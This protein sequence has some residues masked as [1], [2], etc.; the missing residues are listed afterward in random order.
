RQRHEELAPEQPEPEV[1]RQLAQAQL[2]QPRPQPAEDQQRNEDDDQ[3]ADH[4]VCVR[5]PAAKPSGAALKAGSQPLAKPITLNSSPISCSL[6]SFCTSAMTGS[7][8]P[9]SS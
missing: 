8:A 5:S 9:A 7:A 3:P 1:P 2:L 4:S 6:S